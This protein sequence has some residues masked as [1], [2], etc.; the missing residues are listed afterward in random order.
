LPIPNE[1]SVTQTSPEVRELNLIEDLSPELADEVIPGFNAYSPSGVVEGE[2]VYANY[3]RPEDFEEL[4]QRGIS[5]KDKIVITRYG[6]NFRGVKP[7]QAAQHGA[8]GVLIYSDPQQ[9]GFARGEVYPNGPWRPADAIE[10][11][12]VLAISKYPGDPLTPGEPSKP[13]VE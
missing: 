1:L 7:D 6:E 11:G 12:S 10:R 3:G 9:D 5:V 13:G 8:K 4:K 2:L